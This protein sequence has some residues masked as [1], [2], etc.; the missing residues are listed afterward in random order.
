MALARIAEHLVPLLALADV[1][2]ARVDAHHEIRRRIAHALEGVD[3][4]VLPFV[5]PAVLADHHADLGVADAQHAGHVGAGLEVAVLVEDVVRG[6]ELLGVLQHHLAGMDDEQHVVQA[7]AWADARHRRTQHPVQVA[8]LARG[9][10]QLVDAGSHA[11]HEMQL[12]EQVAGVVAG[13]R[14]LREHDQLGAVERGL[15]RG[16]DHLLRVA[17]DVA[18][19]VVEL[20]DGD[21]N[22]QVTSFTLNTW[23]R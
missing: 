5:V 4:V 3:A 21:V 19:E 20:G 17:F 16:R 14:Q 11:V 6:Q 9:A 2:G 23:R 1:G 22:H 8:Q 12:V 15:L 13:E 10:A 18:N 7:L